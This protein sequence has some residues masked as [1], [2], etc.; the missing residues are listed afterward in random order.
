MLLL[1]LF[2]LYASKLLE[3]YNYLKARV[4]IIRF[5]NDINILTYSTSIEANN[6][7]LKGV[8]T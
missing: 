3:I 7:T 5:I 4:F 8:Y 6:R 1:I 2:I